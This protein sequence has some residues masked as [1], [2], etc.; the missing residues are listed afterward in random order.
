[1]DTDVRKMDHNHDGFRDLPKADQINVANKWLYAADNGTQVRWGWKFVQENRLGGMIGYKNTAAMREAMLNDW[2]WQAE[3]KPM[4]LYGSHIRNRGANGYFKV[5]TP[6]GPSVYDEEEADEMRS[7]LAFVVDFDHF[8]EDAYFGLNDYGGNENTLSA[9]L[10]YAHYFTYRSSLNVGLQG[11]TSAVRETLLNKTPWIAGQGAALY[12]LNR[13]EHEAGAYAEYTYTIKDKFSLVAGVRGDYNSYYDKFYFTPRGHVKWN[14][15]PTTTL[16]ASA[17]LGYR[18]TNVITDNIG[19]LATGRRI[20][21]DGDTAASETAFR[22]LDRMEMALT[23]GG[24]LTQTFSALGQDN[25]TLSFDYFRTQFYRAVVADQEWNPQY[26][27]IYD[28]RGRSFTD[29]YQVDFSWT[30][31][32]RL[33][34][35]ATF[36][37]T[38]SEMTIDRPDGTTKRVERPLVSR[39]KTLLN[40]Q[41]ATKF[42]RWVFDATAQLNGPSRV[43]RFGAGGQPDF[44]NYSPS[45]PMFFAQ[46]SRKL[47]KFD[48]YVGC[49]NIADYRQ[50]DPIVGAGNP[51]SAEFNSMNVWGPLMGRKFYIGMRWNLY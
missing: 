4:P 38:D 3:G 40:I 45:Y 49:E 10:M 26:I 37:Y 29:T 6:V 35:F 19:I 11:H 16:R 8:N 28:S 21:F 7:N 12:K 39:Y 44:D 51:W 32:E 36:R 9:N 48:V 47:G 20:I 50:K 42:R 33:D 34:I 27:N 14:I 23:A 31:V 2:D 18:S 1:M 41:Y 13:T 30:P 46:V 5:G 17:G 22:S 15:T 24:S 25:M 43:P